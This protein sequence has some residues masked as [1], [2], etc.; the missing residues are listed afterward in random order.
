MAGLVQGKVGL[1][2]GAGS[3][4]GRA[5][6][7]LFAREGAQVVISDLQVEHGQETL[8]IVQ[9][10]GGDAIFVAADVTRESDVQRLVHE[11]LA[12]YGRLDCAVNNAGV[13]G[14]G[15]PITELEL[16]VRAT[17]CLETARITTLG[18]LVVKSD[19]ELL[20]IV[21]FSKNL[22]LDAEGRPAPLIDQVHHVMG[23]W[24]EGDVRK[25]DDYVEERGL[26]R[27]PLFPRLLQALVELARKDNQQD[28]RTLLERIMNHVTAR[29]THPQMRLG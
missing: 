28:E 26:R 14:T 23:L 2:T 20:K 3:G 9:D 29:G 21:R 8:R 22:G 16:S 19:A 12:K 4:I 6:A 13:I 1:V 25:V 5:T 10:A 27:N 7:M 18:E 17:N 24:R 15:K 11:T